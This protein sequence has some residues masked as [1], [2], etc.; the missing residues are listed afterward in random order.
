MNFQ[1]SSVVCPE[2]GHTF[3]SPSRLEMSEL[4]RVGKARVRALDKVEL[5]A[6]LQ[7]VRD[8]LGDMRA[9]MSRL[10]KHDHTLHRMANVGRLGREQ[11]RE[12]LEG[13]R[14]R[15]QKLRKEEDA[16]LTKL[17]KLKA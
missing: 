6:E 11:L 17:R 5:L 2:C 9:K 15:I 14:A 3:A 16:L 8:F 12:S 4:K 7:A 10:Q 1:Q 13:A